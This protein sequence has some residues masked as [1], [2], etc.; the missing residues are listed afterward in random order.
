M[1]TVMEPDGQAPE[2]YRN[3][4]FEHLTTA[5]PGQVVICTV[6]VPAAQTWVAKGGA[7]HVG[8]LLPNW[9][10]TR[11]NVALPTPAVDLVFEQPAA[12]LV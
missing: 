11:L 1:F 6:F 7:V 9:M 8:A 3:T 4:P 2:I 10:A 5:D 12:P